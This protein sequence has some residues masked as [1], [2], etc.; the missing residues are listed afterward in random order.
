[1][2]LLLDENLSPKLVDR[3]ADVFLGSAHVDR[4]GLGGATDRAVWEHA[5]LN[6]F[7]LVSKDS[8]FNELSSLFGYPPKVVWVRRGNCTNSQIE[9]L[10][11]GNSKNLERLWAD[12]ESGFL[13]LA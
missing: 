8:D 2:K 11:R 5:R 10:L 13:V 9:Q 4:L 6:G 12:P 7:T 1:M 3:L